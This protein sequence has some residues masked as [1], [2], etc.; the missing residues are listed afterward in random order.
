MKSKLYLKIITICLLITVLVV[1][2]TACAPK[3]AASLVKEAENVMTKASNVTINDTIT[4]S[5]LKLTLTETPLSTVTATLSGGNIVLKREIR[6]KDIDIELTATGIKLNV[7][8]SMVNMAINSDAFKDVTF[9]F[10]MRVREE[11]LSYYLLINGLDKVKSDLSN[12]IEVT[13]DEVMKL[14]NS[15]TE[16]IRL[17]VKQ[18]LL[19]NYSSNGEYDKKKNEYSYSYTDNEII[20][21]ELT[22]ALNMFIGLDI[23]KVNG[24]ATFIES[25]FGSKDIEQI[26]NEI[27]T[28][29][30]YNVLA[31]VKNSKY[32]HYFNTVQ[33]ELSST[34]TLDNAI[35][36]NIL[37][38]LGMDDYL[39]SD[40]VK[41]TLKLSIKVNSEWILSVN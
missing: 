24:I 10:R 32:G 18:P 20:N 15:A 34:A 25:I 23:D 16:V 29:N 27:V 19:G 3:D 40:K 39:S 13:T 11:E 6:G 31:T 7:T 22:R 36:L 2:L 35:T 33:S 14:D 4:L 38:A 8:P 41:A 9:L 1:A 12:K 21:N 30:K 5:T 17:L 28:H 26:A 37:N